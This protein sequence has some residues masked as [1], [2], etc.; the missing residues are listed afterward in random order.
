[1]PVELHAVYLGPLKTC[2][3]NLILSASRAFLYA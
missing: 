3:H 1:V 2:R